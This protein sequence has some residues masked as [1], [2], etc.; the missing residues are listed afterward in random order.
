[1]TDQ[2]AT[3]LQL[4]DLAQKHKT[5]A[6]LRTA[7]G[8]AKIAIH[9]TEPHAGY[10]RCAAVKGGPLLPVAIWRDGGT[11]HVLRGGEPIALERVW[12]YSVWSP[13]PYDWYEAATERGEKW[14]DAAAEAVPAQP[15]EPAER[16]L[17]D[18]NPPAEDEV[19][20]IRSAIENAKGV[21][22]AEYAEI[23]SD[24]QAAAA[25]AMRSRL[26]SLSGD[27]DKK[28][29]AEKKPHFDAAKAV[30]TKWQPVV[31]LGKAAADWLRDRLSDYATKKAR[32]AA[33]AQRKADEARRAELE[34]HPEKRDEIPFRYRPPPSRARPAAPPRSVSSRSPASSISTPPTRISRPSPRSGR[35]S[36]RSCSAW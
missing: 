25:Q 36:R 8:E 24:D 5:K 26:L 13:V 2:F 16:G 30:D 32:A 28:R 18:N 11:L 3:Y 35:S 23:T 7:I 1:M 17:G 12:P 6:S 27:A 20:A 15:Q 19:A 22:E 9:E 29:E 21:A 14:P 10:Y 4:L 31:K 33:E 34:A